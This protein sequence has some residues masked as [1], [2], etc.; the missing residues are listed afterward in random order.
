MVGQK[1][2]EGHYAPW[3]LDMDNHKF[4]LKKMP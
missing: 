3:R 1:V 2:E 4:P